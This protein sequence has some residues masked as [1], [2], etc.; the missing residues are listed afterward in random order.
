[1]LNALGKYELL[2]RIGHGATGRVWRARHVDTSALVAVK[3]LREELADDPDVRARFMREGAVLTGRDLPGVVRVHE[4]VVEQDRVGLVMD[5]IDGPNLREVI[6]LQAPLQP[7]RACALA[8]QMAAS[9]NAAQRAGLVHRDVKPEN[10]LIHKV[11]GSEL[12]LLTDFGLARVLDEAPHSGS[13]SRA[14]GTPNYVAPERLRREPVGPAVDV[15]AL[16]VILFEMVVGWRPFRSQDP[17]ALMLQQLN[18]TPLRPPQVPDDLWIL[19]DECL[20]KDPQNRPATSNLAARLDSLAG[21][22]VGVPALPRT[23]PPTE[24]AV[25]L[26]KAVA[27]VQTS[28][29]RTSGLAGRKRAW[30]AAATACIL[31]AGTVAVAAATRAPAGNSAQSA[32]STAETRTATPVG[33]SP[34]DTSSTTMPPSGEA[35]TAI[36]AT[37]APTA[38]GPLTKAPG[39]EKSATTLPTEVAPTRVPAT[40]APATTAPIAKAPTILTRSLPD[41]TVGR[42]YSAVLSGRGQKPLTW[43]VIG[44][45][46]PNKTSLTSSG[47]ISGGPISGTGNTVFTVKLIDGNGLAATRTLSISTIRLRSDINSDGQ[48]DCADRSIL[49]SNFDKTGSFSQGDVN[50]DGTINIFDLSMMLSDWTGGDSTCE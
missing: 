2:E 7:A 5:L 49:M 30:L 3:V 15:Y 48:V 1:M 50:N 39:P 45:A 29:A 22:L 6:S 37:K 11:R 44:G 46:L 36:P 32:A 14:F 8:G 13:R 42:S 41:G 47:R 20:A 4:T 17:A 34:T 23:D 31:A 38:D 43:K 24:E 35:S 26:L 18:E 40:R 33:A 10:V 19:I 12:A 27:N 25:T 21:S 9:L 28:A 16:G